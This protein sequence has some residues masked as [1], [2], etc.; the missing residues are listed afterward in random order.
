M[1]A[2]DELI[3][4]CHGIAGIALTWVGTYPG[5]TYPENSRVLPLLHGKHLYLAYIKIG[6]GPQS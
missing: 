3:E 2:A 5:R 6:L 1:I 4:G